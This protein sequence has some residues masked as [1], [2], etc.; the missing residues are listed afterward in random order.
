MAGEFE[1]LLDV[2]LACNGAH[3]ASAA[4]L[5]NV[6]FAQKT[7]KSTDSG[8]INVCS[9]VRSME[10][11]I[12]LCLTCWSLLTPQN[13]DLEELFRKVENLISCKVTKFRWLELGAHREH[14]MGQ[15]DDKIPRVCLSVCLWPLLRQQF[16]INFDETLHRI[17]RLSILCYVKRLFA[18][19]TDFSRIF[20]PSISCSV[21]S[22]PAFSSS[23]FFLV[24]HFHVSHFHSPRKYDCNIIIST[25]I[26]PVTSNLKRQGIELCPSKS[27]CP[28]AK[29][30]K[31]SKHHDKSAIDGII[32]A[33]L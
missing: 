23:A 19:H 25:F 6:R 8:L 9:N 16:S 13:S 10:R 30:I 14:G 12:A 4:A 26:C 2:M 3:I 18:F 11:I 21:F 5:I 15:N 27:I 31:W 22:F 24:P 1:D 29:L 7:K 33:I 17:I 28:V 20:Q 32:D